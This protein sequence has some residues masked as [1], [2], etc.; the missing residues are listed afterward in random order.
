MITESDKR[1]AERIS[2]HLLEVYS[3]T[4]NPINIIAE[5]MHPEREAAKADIR[6]LEL[7]LKNT[8]QDKQ[9]L[10]REVTDTMVLA[11]RLLDLVKTLE[12][13]VRM[14]SGGI[15]TELLQQIDQ[16]LAK[17]NEAGI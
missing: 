13:F 7:Y 3:I 10:Q 11:L 14:D 9:K 5:E 4:Y 6:L 17:A 15:N 2:K 1:A 12:I 8:R 16:A